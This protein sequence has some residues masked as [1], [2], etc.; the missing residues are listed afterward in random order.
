MS[1][2]IV[3]ARIPFALSHDPEVW[4]GG[5][6]PI[7]TKVDWLAQYGVTVTGTPK[8]CSVSEGAMRYAR[9]KLLNMHHGNPR[10]RCSPDCAFGT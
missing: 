2:F 5:M 6:R 4:R 9:P 7:R 10:F 8:A 3:R 1:G